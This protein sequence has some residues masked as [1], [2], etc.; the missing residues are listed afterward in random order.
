MRPLSLGAAELDHGTAF[1]RHWPF[2]SRVV[3]LWC[4]VLCLMAGLSYADT[5]V[6]RPAHAKL[7]VEETIGFRETIK[8]G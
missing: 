2:G 5:P 7:S 6:E 1:L 4:G 3:R 8:I